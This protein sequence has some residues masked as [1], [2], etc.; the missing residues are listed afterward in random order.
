MALLNTQLG[1]G[2]F[3]AFEDVRRSSEEHDLCAVHEALS[4]R[5]LEKRTCIRT[6]LGVLGDSLAEALAQAPPSTLQL[7]FELNEGGTTS[8]AR[9]GPLARVLRLP[10][11]VVASGVRQTLRHNLRLHL[12]LQARR[13][14]ALVHARSSVE[15][16]LER[17]GRDP[18]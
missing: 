4:A 12:V 7:F 18:Q 11:F 10:S 14:D 16:Q 6:A 5:I 17:L 9:L 8:L 2:A 1:S 13:L 15:S 3:A